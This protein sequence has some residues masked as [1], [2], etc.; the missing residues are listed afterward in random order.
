MDTG[1]KYSF[2]AICTYFFNPCFT[3]NGDRIW[4]RLWRH[5]LGT[6]GLPCIRG[7]CNNNNW[8]PS[9][10]LWGK[11]NATYCIY[12][13]VGVI[14]A[15]L[16]HDIYTLIG[17]RILQGVAVALVPVSIRI[18]REIVGEKKLPMAQGII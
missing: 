9:R 12:Y 16:A 17:L 14:L 2:S 5:H 7:F 8:P 13:T 18:A 10:P 3:P 1:S 15:P 11:E 6:Y 4:C